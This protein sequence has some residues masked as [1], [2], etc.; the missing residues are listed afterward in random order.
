M[1]EPGSYALALRTLERKGFR[2]NVRTGGFERAEQ[3][4]KLRWNGRV[5]ARRSWTPQPA[6]R[7]EATRA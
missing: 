7:P 2:L 1:D 4:V 5:Y 3:R 6:T